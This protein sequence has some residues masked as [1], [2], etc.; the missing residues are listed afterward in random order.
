MEHEV[1]PMVAA[2]SPR[3]GAGE[4]DFCHRGNEQNEVWSQLEVGD[5]YQRQLD[6]IR[7]LAV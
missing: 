2:E 7:Q 6:D 4:M 1:K 3:T 5:T